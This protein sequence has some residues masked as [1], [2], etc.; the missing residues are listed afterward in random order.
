MPVSTAGTTQATS[1][2][3]CRSPAIVVSRLNALLPGSATA[4]AGRLTWLPARA[5][6]RR[7]S[8]S[9]KP[10]A[11][12]ESERQQRESDGEHGEP[13]AD[14]HE[15]DHQDERGHGQRQR[16]ER[17]GAVAAQLGDP[18]WRAARRTPPRGGRRSSDRPDHGSRS[19]VPRRIGRRTTP[20]AARSEHRS[21]GDDDGAD[22]HAPGW[23]R[24]PTR[25]ERG[26][27]R[28]SPWPSAS[29][30]AGPTGANR[31]R[32][33][34]R[35]RAPSE[36]CW[37][38]R[39][40]AG[41]RRRLRRARAPRTVSCTSSSGTVRSLRGEPVGDGQA[42]LVDAGRDGEQPGRMRAAYGGWRCSA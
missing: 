8:S 24:G 38:R 41:R 27:G 29:Q 19:D 34:G 42:G 5:E 4:Y 36:R 11:T 37:S 14:G 13:A 30:T 16:D 25:G 40:S 2:Q 3:D 15:G 12:S 1:S 39:A 20:R 31:E 18:G 17:V 21:D 22:E 32:A 6:S 10:R 33:R 26:P 9:A 35:G 7:R 23:T 28:R